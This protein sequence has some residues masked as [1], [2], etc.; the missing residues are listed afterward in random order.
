M[1]G[2]FRAAVALI[3][4]L[5]VAWTATG[6]ESSRSEQ[7]DAAGVGTNAQTSWELKDRDERIGW[8]LYSQP[9][10]DSRHPRY[11]VVW[12][13]REP[14]QRVIMALQRKSTDDRYLPKTQVRRVLSRGDDFMVNHML[15]DAPFIAD[16]DAVMLLSWHTDSGTGA[17]TIEWAPPVQ[18]IPPVADGTVRFES[19]G[20]WSATPLADGRTEVVYL[21]HSELGDSVPRWLISRMM[22][23]QIVGELLTL[24]TILAEDL[25]AVAASP[26]AID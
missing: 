15:I 24:R 3:P 5:L 16:R 1:S 12:R 6:A 4:T 17:Y 13:T 7:R 11:R 25:P 18:G 8:A 10:A 26:P 20:S 22:N 23:D 14:L 9:V 2:V 19:R 21:Q